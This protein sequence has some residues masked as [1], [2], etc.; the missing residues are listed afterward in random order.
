MSGRKLS[1]SSGRKNSAF[2]KK[3]LRP[4]VFQQPVLKGGYL[5]KQSSGPVKKWQSRYFEISGHYLNYYEKKEAR[6]EQAV[7]GAFDLTIEVNDGST[8]KP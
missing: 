8:V 5:E 7:K 4:S 3:S 1:S 6:S 2:S